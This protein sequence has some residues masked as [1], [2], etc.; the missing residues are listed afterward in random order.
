MDETNEVI[1]L[2][3]D[4]QAKGKFNLAEVVKG[5]GFPEDVIDIYLDIES[6]Y[7]LS[8]LNNELVTITDLD[9]AAP[10]EEKAKVLADKI[11][12]SK[13]TFHLR[14]VS[15]AVVE[16]IEA[17]SKADKPD[18]SDDYILDYFSRLIAATIVKVVD[19]DGNEDDH[20]F[21]LE[22]INDLRGMLPSES[23]EKLVATTQKLTLASGYFRGLTDAGFLPKS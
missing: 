17:L 18:D 1:Q 3:K 13:L 19:A 22:E 14:G 5:R 7:E 16:N 8:K 23:W 10:L 11:I 21:T 6:A 15:Q 12:K 20:L 2:V 9:E 4:A